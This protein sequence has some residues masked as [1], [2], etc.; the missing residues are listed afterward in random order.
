[1]SSVSLFL[2]PVRSFVFSDAS[3]FM[4]DIIV[5]SW[6]AGGIAA[7]SY[8]SPGTKP[9]VATRHFEL[10]QSI[11]T[12]F[13]PATLWSRKQEFHDPPFT[14]QWATER[15]N[16]G[17]KQW[18]FLTSLL[19]FPPF[20]EIVWAHELSW[21][22]H[23]LGCVGYLTHLCDCLLCC[24]NRGLQED[25]CVLRKLVYEFTCVIYTDVWT[26]WVSQ[27]S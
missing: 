26:L 16:D 7:F 10:F 15:L 14:E 12:P 17:L 11:V 3:A 1:M 8:P 21:N 4:W 9:F 23:K 2:L 13:M 25:G 20:S 27:F 22:K 5:A 6:L 19:H 18:C 24:V